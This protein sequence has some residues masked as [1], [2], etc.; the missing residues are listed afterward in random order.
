VIDEIGSLKRAAEDCER[1][2]LLAMALAAVSIGLNAFSLAVKMYLST[3][4][5]GF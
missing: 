4:S 2:S 5:G 3:I 1:Y